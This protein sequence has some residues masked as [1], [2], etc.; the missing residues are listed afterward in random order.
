LVNP[1]ATKPGSIVLVAAGGNV[2]ASMLNKIASKYRQDRVEP[3]N[4]ASDTV[5][6]EGRI[7]IIDDWEMVKAS[8]H[9]MFKCRK[10]GSVFGE[11]KEHEC[12]REK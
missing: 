6:E 12:K 9:L 10:C 2:S 5:H 1:L 4:E 7:P 3:N 11:V 8:P